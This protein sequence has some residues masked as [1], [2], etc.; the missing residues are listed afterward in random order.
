MKFLLI[1]LSLLASL[2][3]RDAHYEDEVDHLLKYVQTTECSYIRNGTSYNGEEAREHIEKKYDYFKDDIESV[4]DFIRLS[5]TK[6]LIF[7]SK[8]YIACPHKPKVESSQW[9][10]SELHRYRKEEN[11]K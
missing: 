9:L 10:L 7:G 11:L 4:E 1:I 6:S 5:A 2:S 8:Y 3:A